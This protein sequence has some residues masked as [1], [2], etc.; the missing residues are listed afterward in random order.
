MYYCWLLQGDRT[1]NIGDT[2]LFQAGNTPPFI[3]ILREV[4][5]E[6]EDLV[7][8]KVMAP[9]SRASGYYCELC[10]RTLVLGANLQEH[11]VEAIHRGLMEASKKMTRCQLQVFQEELKVGRRKQKLPVKQAIL[12]ALR[13]PVEPSNWC[14]PFFLSIVFYWVFFLFFEL[15][16]FC[17]LPH[18]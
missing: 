18:D 3:R 17:L 10:D 9:P 6:K 16:F 2:A 14:V 1:L 4:T 11:K 13:E 8:Y 5:V 15:F 7:K 12:E